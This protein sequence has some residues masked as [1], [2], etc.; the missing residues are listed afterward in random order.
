MFILKTI[1]I[2][3]LVLE[4]K[5]NTHMV[6]M[7]SESTLES[8]CVEGNPIHN[9][10]QSPSRPLTSVHVCQEPVA[11]EY[12]LLFIVALCYS[13]FPVFHSSTATATA[14]VPLNSVLMRLQDILQATL[15][16]ALLPAPGSTENMSYIG[17]ISCMHI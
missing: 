12:I 7:Y 8:L 2:Y 13:L 17:H 14:T 6:K 3:G 11:C 10:H 4:L 1:L 9:N 16:I 15:A 5:K